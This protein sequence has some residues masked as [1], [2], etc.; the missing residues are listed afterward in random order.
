[1][2]A[3]NEFNYVLMQTYYTFLFYVN[4]NYFIIFNSQRADDK[5]SRIY[6]YGGAQ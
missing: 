3:R 4:I 6:G 1:M 5:V 2:F